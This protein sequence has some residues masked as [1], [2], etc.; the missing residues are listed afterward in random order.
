VLAFVAALAA[1]VTA[2]SRSDDGPRQPV[3]LSLGLALAAAV[4]LSISAW[5]FSVPGSYFSPSLFLPFGWFLLGLAWIGWV[6]YI[7]LRH[8]SAFTPRQAVRLL[9]APLLGVMAFAVVET[10]AAFQV[11]YAASKGAMNAVA[12]EVAAGS[13]SPQGI[14]RIGL[15]N[16]E[17][18][19]RVRGGM[20]FLVEDTG[21]LDP[22]GFAY[23][24]RGKPPVI[25]E[26]F[27]EHFDGPWW[28]WQESW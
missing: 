11:R 27:Y 9:A 14:D 24:P 12:R 3:G 2:T 25:G 18:V 17:K 26:D 8:R 5:V 19:E 7:A 21:F 23:S 1:A 10:D 13:R 28:I 20:R 22:V 16:V 15:W 4:L 6:L